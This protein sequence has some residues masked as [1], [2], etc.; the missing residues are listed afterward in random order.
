MRRADSMVSR[1]RIS[2]MRTTSGSCRRADFSEF[3]NEC[4]RLVA[5][6]FDD[7]RKAQLLEAEDLVG[8]LAVDGGRGAALVEDV[9]AEAGETFDAE[10]NVE[11]EV[12]FETVLLRV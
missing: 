11:L 9:R 5:D 7:L 4:A 3:A 2:P 1:S 10:G 8:D 12:F 6:L